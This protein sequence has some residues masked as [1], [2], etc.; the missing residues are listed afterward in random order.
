[1][2]CSSSC[3]CKSCSSKSNSARSSQGKS[4]SARYYQENPD[5]R[6]KKKAY[7]TKYHSTPERI[8]YRTELGKKNREMGSKKGDGKDVSH[9]KNGGFVLESAS[10]NRARNRGKK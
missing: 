5:S 9:T 3:K 2:K 8:K 10:K 6:E 4:K 1:M 7:D